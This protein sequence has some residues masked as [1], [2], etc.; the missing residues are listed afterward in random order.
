MKEQRNAS[1]KDFLFSTW[2]ITHKTII[3]VIMAIFL[4]L[5]ISS[6][7][8]MPR[9]NF[10]EIKQT[11]VFLSAAYPGNTAEDVEQNKDLKI[12]DVPTD[13]IVLSSKRVKSMKT[14]TISVSR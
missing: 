6:Y 2:A 4:F 5:G 11:N 10:P 8:T 9:E 13:S 1:E 3:Y 12:E 14:S 7:F